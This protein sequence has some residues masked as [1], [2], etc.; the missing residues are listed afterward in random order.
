MPSVEYKD[1]DL[2]TDVEMR[3]YQDPDTG[4]T[5][6]YEVETPKG[7]FEVRISKWLERAEGYHLY[8]FVE[9]TSFGQ[10]L[11]A[12]SNPW[13]WVQNQFTV[14]DTL[15]DSDVSEMINGV[16]AVESARLDTILDFGNVDPVSAT[17][18]SESDSHFIFETVL[19]GAETFDIDWLTVD[20][21]PNRGGV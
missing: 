14:A 9:V 8:G 7:P 17:V 6:T 20:F 4:E 13:V 5:V 2:I 1:T 21:D 16:G 11:A 19:D 10:D 3:E 15:T 18:T 12:Q